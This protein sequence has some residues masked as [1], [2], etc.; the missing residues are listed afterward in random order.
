M[1][2]SLGNSPDPLELIATYGA[3]ALRFG[4]MRSAPLGQ[5]V[6]FDEK[7]VELGRNFCN[8]LWNACRFRQMQ[9]GEV[10]A[11]IDPKLLTTDD[12]WI[13][14]KLDQAL[15][16]VSVAFADYKFNEATQTLYRFFW[17]EYC[18]WY[19]EASKSVLHGQDLIRKANTVAVIDFILSH[20]LRLFHPFMPFI[21]EELWHGMG[22][23]QDMPADQGGTTIMFAP[24]PKA[25]G[26]DFLLHYGLTGSILAAVDAKYELV[27]QGRNLR[28]EANIPAGKKVSFVLKPTG[29]VS[30][31]DHEVIRLLL[32]AESLTID[33]NYQ[34][35]KGTATLH[36]QLGDLYLP[37]DGLVDVAAERTRLA[38]ELEKVASEITKVE[39]KLGN[40]QF[41]ERVPANV[42]QEH[43][44]RL[45]E[46]QTKH[47]RL[48]AALED[49]EGK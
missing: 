16:E 39:Q 17:N 37:L 10:Q 32:N 46:W 4:T 1:S 6:L 7:D 23:H 34:A 22:Y 29:E 43:Q 20:A 9:G 18:D 41:V 44:Q 26:E 28:R 8:K 36:A 3:D 30:A 5:D 11:E 49:L 48:K 35:K 2:K 14:L 40:P 25:L 31:H 38:K 33:L 21:T 27:S 15:R 45:V 42:L 12:K 47:G 24:W 19:V 13:L